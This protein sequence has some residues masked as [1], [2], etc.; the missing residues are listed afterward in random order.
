MRTMLAGLMLAG[1]LAGCGGGDGGPNPED[2]YGTYD[3]VWTCDSA[4]GCAGSTSFPLTDAT[5]ATID[6]PEQGHDYPTIVFDTP[7]TGGDMLTSDTDTWITCEPDPS[8]ST[9]RYCPLTLTATGFTF[10]GTYQVTAGET[11]D[12]SL[13]ATRR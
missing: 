10:S 1:L 8:G 12:W 13:V 7:A 5:A 4:G 3:L 11:Y 9:K 2:W 6:A